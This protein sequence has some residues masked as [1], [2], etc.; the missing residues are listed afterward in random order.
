V[1]IFSSRKPI[2]AAVQGAAI[3]GGLGLA[4]SADFRVTCPEGRFAANFTRLGFHPGFGLTTTLPELIG[5]QKASMVFY[6]SRRFKG[7]E[8]VEMGMADMLVPLADVRATAIELAREIA[9]NAPLAVVATRD[10]LRA[11]LAERVAAATAHEL[12]QQQWLQATEDFREGVKATSERRV[13]N[14]QGR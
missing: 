3:G 6:T 14:F 13:P 10:T 4:I 9:T 8:A 2:I 5:R 1:R 7:E 12:K 11:G